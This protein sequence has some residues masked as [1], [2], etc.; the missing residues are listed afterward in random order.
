LILDICKCFKVV[1]VWHVK[2][3]ELLQQQLQ[4]VCIKGG[5][6]VSIYMYV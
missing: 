2:I 3:T 5:E 4:K 6:K 1:K